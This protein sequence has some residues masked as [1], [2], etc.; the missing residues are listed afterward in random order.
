[1]SP[2]IVVISDQEIVKEQ[3]EAAARRVIDA[4]GELPEAR[5]LCFFDDQDW[6][7]FKRG[8]ATRG[9][10]SPVRDELLE[11]SPAWVREQLV[12]I[13]TSG[14]CV[15]AFDHLIYV[16]GSTC[17]DHRGL[18]LTFAHE[19]HHFRQYMNTP[20]LS[21]ASSLIQELKKETLA[22]LGW[23]DW[24]DIPHE[25]DARIVGKQ[26]ASVIL[27]AATVQEFIASRI[28]QAVNDLDQRDWQ[29]M[30]QIGAT[31]TYD[32][33]AG[34]GAAFRRLRPYRDEL[35]QLLLERDGDP[36]FPKVDLDTLFSDS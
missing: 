31:D 17:S 21:A 14:L 5:L 7:K 24:A 16:H 1:M 35:Q 23:K 20:R 12:S 29:F 8:K 10:Y 13:G 33:A 18:T 36:T 3:R 26:I 19:L 27:G 25:R 32:L 9:L 30:Y 6:L 34:V 22:E 2:K 4:Y 28:P 11:D 15:N